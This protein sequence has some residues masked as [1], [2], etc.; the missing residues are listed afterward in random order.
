MYFMQKLP[1]NKTNFTF[2]NMQDFNQTTHVGP[3]DPIV[4][5]DNISFYFYRIISIKKLMKQSRNG[6]SRLFQQ[7]YY[8]IY[9][10]FCAPYCAVLCG[11]EVI[12]CVIM[13]AITI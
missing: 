6:T 3:Q 7:T 13:S 5:T 11:H 9:F 10:P 1:A 8:T 4:F 2:K 12:M